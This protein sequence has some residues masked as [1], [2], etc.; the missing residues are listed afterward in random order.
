MK[1]E[2]KRSRRQIKGTK[3]KEENKV[4][5]GNKGAVCTMG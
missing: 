1:G 5:G 3:T 2:N 4:L